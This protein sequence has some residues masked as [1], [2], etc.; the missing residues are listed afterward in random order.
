MKITH[1]IGIVVIAV[2]IGMIAT[3]MSD[4]SLYVN[5]SQAKEMAQNGKTTKIHVVGTLPKDKKGKVVGLEYKPE[6]NPNFFAFTLTDDN[7]RTERVI[8]HDSKP[9]DF[10]VSEQVV[11]I[12]NYQNNQFVAH[13][14][15]MK[16]PSKYEDKKLEMKTASIK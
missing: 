8:Y 14:I 12:G 9:T 15:L 7:Q 4:A 10:E 1:I 11:V 3:T 16:C 6:V 5:F 2:A 13:K